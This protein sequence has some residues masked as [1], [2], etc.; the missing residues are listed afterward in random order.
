MKS[1]K[2]TIPFW[3]R[4]MFF[5]ESWSRSVFFTGF[6]FRPVFFTGRVLLFIL[7]LTDPIHSLAQQHFD[8]IIRGGTVVDGTGTTPRLADIGINKDTIAFIGDLSNATTGTEI[9]AHG[10]AVSPGFIN[11]LSWADGTLLQD[12]RAMS[13]V[14]QGVTLEVFGEGWSPG[15]RKRR[16]GDQGW[17]TLGG[18]FDHLQKKGMSPNVASFVGATTVRTYVMGYDNRKPTAAALEQMKALVKQAMEEGA[19]G[20]GSS[21]I[22]TPAAFADTDEL[23]ELS[24]VA[25]AYGGMYITHMRSESDDILKAVDETLQIAR[26]ANIPAEIFHIKINQQRNW[27]K[28]DSVLMKIDS[29][30]K[31]G[32]SIT[33]NFYPY[34]ASATGLK[35]RIPNWAQEGGAK[36][37]RGRIRNPQSRTKILYDMEHGIPSRNSDPGDV[38][39]LGFSKDSLHQLY[40]GKRLNEVAKLHG[41][42]AD[43]TVLDIIAKDPSASAIYFLMSED[44]SVRFLKQPYVSIGSDAGAPALTPEFTKQGIHPRAYGTFA[45]V[46][47]YYVRDKQVLTL[48]EAIHRMTGLPATN[49]RLKKRGLLRPGYFADVTI[50]DPT[51]IQDKATFDQ[52][53]QYATGV[54]YVLVNGVVVVKDGVHTEAKPGVI[55]KR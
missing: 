20:L 39:L 10:L 22:Y 1:N 44:N 18:Y 28:I 41:K 46:L 45:R 40:A 26:R 53:H 47:S 35:E 15:P 23:V 52:P 16:P 9:Q 7:F 24:K 6:G 21:L 37:L 27:P 38:M 34:T 29:A 19:M 14:L 13:D 30:R 4:P 42:N 49:L 12:G 5:T 2:F 55:V 43:E 17:T 32:L 54:S 11:M 50:F 48:E 51:V 36:A 31:S 25:S 33:A 8:T 3:F